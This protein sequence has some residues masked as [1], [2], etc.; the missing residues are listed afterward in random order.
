MDASV[1]L[2]CSSM[3]NTFS[4]KSLLEKIITE[5][6]YQDLKVSKICG[7]YNK[8]TR[9]QIVIEKWKTE[10][11]FSSYSSCVF[12]QSSQYPH[13]LLALKV[14]IAYRQLPTGKQRNRHIKSFTR[15]DNFKGCSWI[16]IILLYCHKELTNCSKLK[17][18]RWC[19]E[20]LLSGRT[21]SLC[22]L[23][24][25]IYLSKSNLSIQRC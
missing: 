6:E 2:H 13:A 3:G 14:T 20:C 7:N 8:D 23:I 9:V 1:S 15:A 11:Q 18:C 22:H 5:I 12:Q 16:Y 4:Y 17:F 24:T 10:K 19:C 21:E 25:P